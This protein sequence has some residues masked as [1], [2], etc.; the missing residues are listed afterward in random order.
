[1][2]RGRP[3]APLE[4]SIEE[5]ETLERLVARRK[6]AQALAQRARLILGCAEGKSNKTVSA[7]VGLSPQTVGKC[8]VVDLSRDA[9]T[10]CSTSRG[11]V[12]PARSPTPTWR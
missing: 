8:G 2:P 6:T 10:G 11:L 3:L 12:R 7:Q 5:R 4:I 1:M 9:W